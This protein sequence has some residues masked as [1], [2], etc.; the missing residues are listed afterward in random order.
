[1]WGHSSLLISSLICW[2]FFMYQLYFVTGTREQGVISPDIMF[3]MSL[4]LSIIA[5]NYSE[6]FWI[7][8]VMLLSGLSLITLGSRSEDYYKT[9]VMVGLALCFASVYYRQSLG[10][11]SSFGISTTPSNIAGLPV[12]QPIYA[13]THLNHRNLMERPVSSNYAT[14]GFPLQRR[15]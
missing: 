12:G 15:F 5:A 11:G 7:N 1:M 9:Y 13:T 14:S 3:M 8:Q 4:F 6:L 10:L 2:L